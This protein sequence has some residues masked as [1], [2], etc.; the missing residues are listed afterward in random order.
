MK[1]KVAVLAILAAMAVF[2]L[3][4][5]RS[6]LFGTRE[7]VR[8]AAFLG[9]VATELNKQLPKLVDQETELTSVSGL[10][11]VI[12]YNYRLVNRTAADVSATTLTEALKPHATKAACGTPETREKFLNQG[13]TMRYTYA[14][15]GGAA[16]ASFD[17]APADCKP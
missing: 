5:A 3:L 15:K 10:E 16:I 7:D 9:K 12:A 8:S 14:D 2:G 4:Q 13:I 17:V 11:G 6:G 1:N